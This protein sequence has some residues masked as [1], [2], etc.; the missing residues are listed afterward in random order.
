MA[1]PIQLRPRQAEEDRLIRLLVALVPDYTAR[2]SR[3][4]GDF[5]AAVA[6]LLGDPVF[7]RLGVGG[8]VFAEVAKRSY[9]GRD[10][11]SPVAVRR[12]GR[13]LVRRSEDVLQ[14]LREAA[15]AHRHALEDGRRHGEALSDT[16]R[17]INEEARSRLAA[18]LEGLSERLGAGEL[19]DPEK[20]ADIL[21]KI[22][23]DAHEHVRGAWRP[24][25]EELGNS[26]LPPPPLMFSGR[27]MYIE[28][29][30]LFNQHRLA[31]GNAPKADGKG[32]RGLLGGSRRS[33]S[34]QAVQARAA[35][36]QEIVE[37]MGE[38][39]ISALEAWQRSTV[40]RVQRRGLETS[41][42]GGEAALSTELAV[43]E[44]AISGL[45]SLKRELA[46]GLSVRHYYLALLQQAAGCSRSA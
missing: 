34:A 5:A 37:Q 45:T 44:R 16:A 13:A 42:S 4:T 33:N 18:Q 43:I 46:Q 36:I 3:L 19:G 28:T 21:V 9:A 1:A 35:A 8:R 26:S 29:V 10:Q 15:A 30:K 25:Y 27:Q 2:L 38:A 11:E 23:G 17:R 40:E 14:A 39:I 41:A 32:L 22:A 20:L 24:L 31:S 12:R 7:E 6:F